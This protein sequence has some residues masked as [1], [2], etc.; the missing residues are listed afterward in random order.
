LDANGKLVGFTDNGN[1]F[2]KFLNR[3]DSAGL[4]VL[5]SG[6]GEDKDLKKW[7]A[8]SE[9][10]RAWLYNNR[11]KL[12]LHFGAGN[13]LLETGAE[14][15]ANAR[16]IGSLLGQLGK[17]QGSPDYISVLWE[18]VGRLQQLS[19][20]ANRLQTAVFTRIGKYVAP[21]L[22][23]KNAI[24]T[25]V[26]ELF[27]K[28]ISQGLAAASGGIAEFLAPLVDRILKP[29][30]KFVTNFVL[31]KLESVAKAVLHGDFSDFIKEQEKFIAASTKGV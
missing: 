27:S 9:R 23:L 8:Q 21:F 12:G 10:F 4:K 18:R 15:Q 11:A 14:G 19:S 1:A 13:V 29:I 2:L 22:Q 20:Y 7:I 26:A 5:I 24:S 17:R 16:V 25:A 28:L 30:I 3:G 31:N 6:V